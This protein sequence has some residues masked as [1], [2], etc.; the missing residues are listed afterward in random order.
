MPPRALAYFAMLRVRSKRRTGVRA[1][2]LNVVSCKQEEPTGATR[3]FAVP[4]EQSV[5]SANSNFTSTHSDTLR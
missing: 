2:A 3:V 5:N 4:Y 1:R